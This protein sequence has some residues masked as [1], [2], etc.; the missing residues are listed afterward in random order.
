MLPGVFTAAVAAGDYLPGRRVIRLYAH[1]Y[2][3][4]LPNRTLWEVWLRFDMLTT[5]MHEVGHHHDATRRVGHGRWR[6]D[7]KE[8]REAYA[9]GMDHRLTHAVVVPYIEQAYPDDVAA[10]GDWLA[11]HGGVAPP[12]AVLAGDARWTDKNGRKISPAM[13][14]VNMALHKLAEDVAA[15]T[16]HLTRVLRF[17]TGLH[18]AALYDE[19]TA[20]ARRVLRGHPRHV[21]ALDLLACIAF[22]RHQYRAAERLARRVLALDPAQAHAWRTLASVYRAAGRW[23]ELLDAVERAIA[24]EYPHGEPS[25]WLIGER[26]EA[27]TGLGRWWRLRPDI[28]RLN[29]TGSERQRTLAAELQAR[30]DAAVQSRVGRGPMTGSAS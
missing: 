10:F 20:V 13:F 25:L 3:P 14:S 6:S 16:D 18:Y 17:A 2:D 4:G 28:E 12:M 1:V 9:Q 27:L 26:A 23:Q 7:R 30:M 24:I 15:G 8:A 22:D 11:R 19:A 21:D 5:F 29:A